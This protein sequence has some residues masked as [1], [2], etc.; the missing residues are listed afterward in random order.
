MKSSIKLLIGLAAGAVI[1]SLLA[2]LFAPDKGTVTRKK[3]LDQG[4]KLTDELKDFFNRENV[5]VPGL[6]EVKKRT[7]PVIDSEVE[8]F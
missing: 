6:K 2:I 1:G 8:A 7:I 3:I 5:P 4:N